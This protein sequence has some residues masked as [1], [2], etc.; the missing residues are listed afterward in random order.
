MLAHTYGKQ[1]HATLF[2]IKM[3]I[4]CRINLVVKESGDRSIIHPG[5]IFK[6]VRYLLDDN[7]HII[8]L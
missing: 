4:K 1:Q 6:Y 7:V 8:K 5:F 2:H 3:Y